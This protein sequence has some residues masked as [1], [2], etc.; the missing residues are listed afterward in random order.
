MYYFFCKAKKPISTVTSSI[1]EQAKLGNTTFCVQPSIKDFP[2]D[3]FTNQQRRFGA[4]IFHILFVVYLLIAI[5][6]LCDEYF[7]DS[8]EIISEVCF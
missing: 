5:T 1:N 2:K 3:L 6:K 4:I 7:M 8:L